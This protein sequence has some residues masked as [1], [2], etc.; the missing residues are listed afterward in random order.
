MLA[1]GDSFEEATEKLQRA[2]DEI[3][4]TLDQK[5]AN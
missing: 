4:K 2:V 3:K 5:M 1:V